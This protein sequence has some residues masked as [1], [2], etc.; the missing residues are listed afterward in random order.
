MLKIQ[1]LPLVLGERE[2]ERERE[3]EMAAVFKANFKKQNLKSLISY[4][5][6]QKFSFF[7][8]LC[9][10]LSLSTMEKVKPL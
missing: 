1:I 6:L 5:P 7:L 2:R 3:R 9:L 4:F 8:F 10:T